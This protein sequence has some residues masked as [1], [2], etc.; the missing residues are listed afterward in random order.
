MYNLQNNYI[1]LLTHKLF[2]LIIISEQYITYYDE[3]HWSWST[4]KMYDK[5]RLNSEH[6]F[7]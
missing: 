7:V 4:K 5:T 1:Y 6:I 2:K 3:K